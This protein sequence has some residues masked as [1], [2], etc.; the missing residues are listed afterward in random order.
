MQIYAMPGI[1]RVIS[2]FCAI[3]VALNA[4]I[5]HQI[6]GFDYGHK[7]REWIMLVLDRIRLPIEGQKPSQIYTGI[8]YTSYLALVLLQAYEFFMQLPKQ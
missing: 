5:I 6:S 7:R 8:L 2:A 3:K 1:C 4:V